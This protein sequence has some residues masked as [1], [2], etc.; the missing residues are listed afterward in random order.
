V[1]KERRE[2]VIHSKLSEV[3]RQRIG[4]KFLCSGG[5]SSDSTIIKEAVCSKF[6]VSYLPCCLHPLLIPCDDEESLEGRV[7]VSVPLH[8]STS[9]HLILVSLNGF[10]GIAFPYRNPKKRC[11]KDSDQGSESGRNFD[12]Q[13]SGLIGRENQEHCTV[14]PAR[15]CQCAT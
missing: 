6:D 11:C 15:H 5:T 1:I 13:S 4:Y 7:Y 9:I 12:D 14:S 10:R 8:K 2:K 3:S